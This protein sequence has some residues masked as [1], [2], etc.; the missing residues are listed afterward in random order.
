MP[1][2]DLLGAAGL[3]MDLAAIVVIAVIVLLLLAAT[4][5]DLCRPNRGR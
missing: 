5:Q 2:I 4:I 1:A 3:L